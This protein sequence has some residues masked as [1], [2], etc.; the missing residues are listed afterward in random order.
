MKHRVALP[1]A[2]ALALSFF[3]SP[4]AAEASEEIKFGPNDVPTVFF[5]NKS[6]DK[7]RVDYAIRLD[8]LCNPVGEDAMF[9]YWREFEN[10]PPVRTHGLNMM[11]RVAYGISDQRVVRRSGVRDEWLIRLKQLPRPITITTAKDPV[12]GKCSATAHTTIIGVE[13]TLSSVYVKLGG[14]MSVDYIDIHGKN[15]ATGQPV[16]ER[17]RK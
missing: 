2:C 13:A 15:T 1:F 12:S 3:A 7:N 11:E 8:A 5:I 14:V 4:R 6:D 17:V 10:S 9:Q 16:V